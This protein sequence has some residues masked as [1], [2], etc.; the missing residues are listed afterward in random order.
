MYLSPATL[1]LNG[2]QPRNLASLMDLYEGN[3]RR[4][5]RLAPDLERLG[6]SA[7]SRVGGALDLHLSVIDRFK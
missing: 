5:M 6:E 3:Y 2:C 1:R 7:I 4:L